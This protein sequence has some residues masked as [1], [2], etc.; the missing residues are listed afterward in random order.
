M[1]HKFR[2]NIGAIA[3][4]A[5]ITILMP[6]VAQAYVDPSTGGQL[7]QLV[8]GGVAGLAVLFRLYWRRFRDALSSRRAVRPTPISSGQSP[9][10]G[11]R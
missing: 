5:T 3:A 7:V 4:L 8:T 10:A 9:D 2:F 11:D 1:G 6:A